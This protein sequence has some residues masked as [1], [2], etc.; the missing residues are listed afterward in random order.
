MAGETGRGRVAVWP[1]DLIPSHDY[2][3]FVKDLLRQSPAIRPEIRSA[4]Q[5]EKPSTVFS[6]LLENRRLAL[7]NFN[8]EPATVRLPGGRELTL[9][10][11]AIVLE[12]WPA[13]TP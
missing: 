7:L 6:S 12:P 2:A 11:Y 4:L 10:P 13:S 3:R 5:I 1:G 8:D 9:S